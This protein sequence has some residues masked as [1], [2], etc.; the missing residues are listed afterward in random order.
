MR[1]LLGARN[2]TTGE[3]HLLTVELAESLVEIHRIAASRGARLRTA[4]PEDRPT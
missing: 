1:P 4:S 2:W 3:L